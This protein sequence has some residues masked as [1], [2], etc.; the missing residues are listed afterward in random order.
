MIPVGSRSHDLLGELRKGINYLGEFKQRVRDR[1]RALS[2]FD[3]SSVSPI[4]LISAVDRVDKKTSKKNY[5]G[6][7]YILVKNVLHQY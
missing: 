1:A 7:F 2:N 6:I 5:L 3:D 4:M